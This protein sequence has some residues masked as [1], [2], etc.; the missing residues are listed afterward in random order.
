M[1]TERIDSKTNK[2]TSRIDK[3]QFNNQWEDGQNHE[4]ATQT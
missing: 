4:N 1:V 2:L 3:K